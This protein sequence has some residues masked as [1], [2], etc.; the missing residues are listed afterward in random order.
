MKTPPVICQA[1]IE[2]VCTETSG[3]MEPIQC[4]CGGPPSAALEGLR[5]GRILGAII[6]E[7]C[8]GIGGGCPA[9]HTMANVIWGDR[10]GIARFLRGM[11]DALLHDA[12]RMTGNLPP[13]IGQGDLSLTTAPASS[14]G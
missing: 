8:N 9:V 2:A 7:G 6:V 14:M 10:H 1:L 11:R 13:E 3:P 5:Y 12:A 4:S